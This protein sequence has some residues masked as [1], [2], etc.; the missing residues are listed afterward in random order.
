[1][2]KKGRFLPFAAFWANT[3][4]CTIMLR[5]DRQE[6]ATFGHLPT[7]GE[8]LLILK[9]VIKKSY[10]N[11]QAPTQAGRTGDACPNGWFVRVIGRSFTTP[12]I[13]PREIPVSC[14]LVSHIPNRSQPTT[15][16]CSCLVEHRPGTHA[17]LITALATHQPPATHPIRLIGLPTSWANEPSRPAHPLNVGKARCLIGKPIQKLIPS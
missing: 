9:A 13:R 8:L 16:R 10:G 3:L 6:S 15:Q 5:C 12:L 4:H 14:D 11:W 17:S 1:M 7:V 2:T